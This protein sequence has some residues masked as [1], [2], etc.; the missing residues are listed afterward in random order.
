V[1]KLTLGRCSLGRKADTGGTEADQSAADT[2]QD[3]EQ[4]R[5]CLRLSG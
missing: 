5:R 4:E 3:A 2:D 1:R